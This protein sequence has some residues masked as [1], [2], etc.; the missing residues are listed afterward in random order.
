MPMLRISAP[1]VVLSVL[2]LGCG[3]SKGPDNPPVPHAKPASTKAFVPEDNPGMSPD[4]LR[5]SQE[6][7]EALRR[8]REA[9]TLPPDMGGGVVKDG[10]KGL[11]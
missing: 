4:D 9:G 11:K 6:Q 8:A 10:T 2:C 5:K 1:L 7:F 3:G